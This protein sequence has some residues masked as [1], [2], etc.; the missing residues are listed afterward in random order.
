MDTGDAMLI[1]V[2]VGKELDQTKPGIAMDKRDDNL[3]ELRNPEYPAVIHRLRCRPQLRKHIKANIKKYE[4]LWA[5]NNTNVGYKSYEMDNLDWLVN[6][7]ITN[8]DMNW[9]ILR[10]QRN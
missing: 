7:L 6:T 3:L 10:T 8:L 4:I 1:T 5:F 2:H 9:T